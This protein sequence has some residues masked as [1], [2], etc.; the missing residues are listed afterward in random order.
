MAENRGWSYPHPVLDWSDDIASTFVVTSV[1]ARS[2]VETFDLDFRIDL[3][4]P[5]L[6]SLIESG[7]ALFTAKWRCARTFSLGQIKPV[8][9]TGPNAAGFRISIPQGRLA[10]DFTVT[11]QVVADVQID[12]YRPS[13]ANPDYGQAA[14]S[15]S[16]G[17]LLAD[18][19]FIVLD[20][21]KDY[22]PLNPPFD[23]CFRFEASDAVPRG[24]EISYDNNDYVLVSFSRD[25]YVGFRSLDAMPELQIGMFMLPAL[26][27]AL[28]FIQYIDESRGEGFRWAEALKSLVEK[29]APGEEAPEIQAQSILED[30]LARAF[31]SR[32]FG[33]E[34]DE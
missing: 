9:V 16:A 19:G 32:L 25:L 3:D 10:G 21:T 18:G 1:T 17:D 14:F 30:P 11:F 2:G 7:A 15:V 8:K 24:F 22:D 28:T 6:Q 23:S 33:V 13:R 31:T 29:H 26:Q 5:D 4:D 27:A 20:A 12:E 34:E